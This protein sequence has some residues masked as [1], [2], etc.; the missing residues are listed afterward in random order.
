MK[1]G[2]T[3]VITVFRSRLRP[4]AQEQYRQWA[5]RMSGLARQMPGYISHK[6]FVAEDGERVTIV[7]FDSE[8]SHR[9]WA[10]HPEHVAAKKKGRSSFY[11]EYCIQVCSLQRESVFP[12]SAS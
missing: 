10:V 8:E 12:D 4:E 6:T 9:A 3:K 2:H 5:T 11:Q 1:Q 7:E